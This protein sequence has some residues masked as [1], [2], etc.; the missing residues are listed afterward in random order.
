M[1]RSKK[2]E[3]YTLGGI[4]LVLG[5]IV[6]YTLFK[7]TCHWNGHTSCADFLLMMHVKLGHSSLASMK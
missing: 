2:D 3:D 1:R 6:Q 7:S 5:Y 4:D